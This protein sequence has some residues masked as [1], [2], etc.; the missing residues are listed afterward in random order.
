MPGIDPLI[1][2]LVILS[3]FMELDVNV[4]NL[5]RG[6][7][8]YVSIPFRFRDDFLDEKAKTIFGRIEGGFFFA[9]ALCPTKFMRYVFEHIR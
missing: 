1:M 2:F 6:A 7:G 4:V 8:F 9:P 5:E 3:S